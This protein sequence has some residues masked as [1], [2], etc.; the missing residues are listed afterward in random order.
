M[1]SEVLDCVCGSE[2]EIEPCLGPILAARLDAIDQRIHELQCTR[3]SL[4]ALAAA[5]EGRQLA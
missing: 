3:C 5:T 1:I 2:A 4:A